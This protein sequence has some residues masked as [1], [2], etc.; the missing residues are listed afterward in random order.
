MV[1]TKVKTKICGITNARD[2]KRAI[3]AGAEFLGFNFYEKSPRYIR[4]AAAGRIA[5]GLPRRVKK[6]G[7]FVNEAE[8]TVVAIA[9]Q[10]PLNF[11]QLHG[12]ET[13]AFAA[14]VARKVR[15][16]KALRVKRG[17]RAAELRSFRVATAI[18]LDGFDPTRRGGTGKTFDW[19]VAARAAKRKRIFLAGGLTP[20]NI[21]EAIRQVRPFAVDVCSGVES[22]PGKKSAARLAAL[23]RAV[24][25]VRGRKK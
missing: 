24:A 14:R 10:V 22:R 3:S 13:P 20:E 23:K 1:K 8:E 25:E 21:G 19:S 17:F 6:V 15:V 5:R 18:L 4:P 9:R 16:I 11:V 7:V 2:A 12:D